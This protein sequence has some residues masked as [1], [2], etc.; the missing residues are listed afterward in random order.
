MR[1]ALLFLLILFTAV[2]PSFALNQEDP[3]LIRILFVGNSLTYVGNLP[4]VLQHLATANHKLME[5]DM[6][7]KGGATLT[8]RVADGSVERALQAKHM[9]T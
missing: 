3:K 2:P 4:A 9:I 7:V 1:R 8:E 5:V 6:I